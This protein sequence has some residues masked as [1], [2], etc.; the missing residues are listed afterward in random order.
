MKG[1]ILLIR[2]VLATGLIWL[3]SWVLPKG[4]A[5]AAFCSAINERF[6]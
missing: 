2:C 4:P 6:R 5:R 3:T 1:T